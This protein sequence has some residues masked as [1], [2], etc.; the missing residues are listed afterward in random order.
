MNS[1]ITKDRPELIS[2]LQFCK[3]HR[4]PYQAA[5]RLIKKGV[6]PVE[7]IGKSTFINLNRLKII[8]NEH[9]MDPHAFVVRR[10]KFTCKRV[11][12]GLC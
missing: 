3:L 11:R 2:V 1:N 7:Q 9:D 12:G 5:V 10:A 4:I 6:V 8:A